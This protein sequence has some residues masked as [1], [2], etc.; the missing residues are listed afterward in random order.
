MFVMMMMMIR[1]HCRQPDARDGK[2]RAGLDEFKR[3]SSQRNTT[4][5]VRP[6]TGAHRSPAALQSRTS[7]S[8]SAV[9]C[10]LSAVRHVRG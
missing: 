8:L 6:T 7:L 2:H 4:A 5:H 1:L 3:D 10:I 9:L